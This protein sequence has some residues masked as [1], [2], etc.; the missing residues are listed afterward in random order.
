MPIL[1]WSDWPVCCAHTDR[2]TDRH[3]SN[4][5]I[6]SA[7]H[8]VHLAEIMN[9]NHNRDE[10]TRLSKVHTV[11]RLY[12]WIPQCI[13]VSH[14]H[15]QWTACTCFTARMLTHKFPIFKKANVQHVIKGAYSSHFIATVYRILLSGDNSQQQQ[16]KQQWWQ[17]W[18]TST[19]VDT[20]RPQRKR[21]TKEYLEKAA[22]ERSVEK[23][24]LSTAG[25]DGVA[26]QDRAG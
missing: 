9:P 5:H 4:E 6:I 1:N 19:T 13:Q 23:Q 24:H 2:N 11:Q 15:Y 16:I 25:E 26:A 3:T 18:Q 8:F 22:Q 10:K 7:I 21:S 20:A 12:V 14:I 17:H